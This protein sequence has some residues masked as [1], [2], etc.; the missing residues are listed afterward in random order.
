MLVIRKEQMDALRR[1]ALEKYYC[2]ME[3][4]LR[5]KFAMETSGLVPEAMRSAIVD[6]VRRAEDHDITDKNDIRRFLEYLTEYGENFGRSHET[7]WA[8]AVLAQDYLTGTEKVDELDRYE[9]FVLA[10]GHPNVGM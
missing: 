7:A 10:A 9:L 5:L 2:D 4:H 6:G 3:T 1:D 8:G